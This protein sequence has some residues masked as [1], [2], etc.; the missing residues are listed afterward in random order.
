VPFTAQIRVF[1]FSSRPLDQ[2]LD[3]NRRRATSAIANARAPNLPLCLL[4]HTQQCGCDPR[5]GRTKRVSQRDRATIHVNLILV[6]TQDL[7]V[8]ERDDAE[9]LVDLEGVDGGLLDSGMGES[10]GHGE[11]GSRGELG[12]VLGSIAPAEDL[13]D[14]GEVVLLEGG[15]GDENEGG[16]AVREGRGVGGGH[17]A[18]FRLEGGAEG[19]RLGLVELRAGLGGVRGEQDGTTHVL[20]LVVRVDDLRGLAATAGHLDRD[21]LLLELAGLGG[22]NGLLVGADAVVVLGLAVEAVLLG[23]LLTLQTHVLG[24]VC[25]G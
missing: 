8:R 21:D 9:S 20:G 15:F 11:R 17:G 10:L 12:G 1:I 19:A 7:H 3:N 24:L 25:V 23:A 18:V 6:D 5:T 13:S 22:G 16:G 4:Q 2:R 14:G